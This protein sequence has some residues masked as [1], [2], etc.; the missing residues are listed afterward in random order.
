ME[1]TDVQMELYIMDSGNKI[2]KMVMG[3]RLIQMGQSISDS[4]KMAKDGKRNLL[5]NMT[6]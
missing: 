3:I 6:N 1:Y 2:L 4:G 5:T